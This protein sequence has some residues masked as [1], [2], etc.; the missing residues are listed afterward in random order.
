MRG[1]QVISRVGWNDQIIIVQIGVLFR[2]KELLLHGTIGINQNGPG[3]TGSMFIQVVGGNNF[4]DYVPLPW[5]EMP[6]STPR[7]SFGCWHIVKAQQ[8]V[9][10]SLHS[11]YICS[12]GPSDLATNF[13]P[14]HFIF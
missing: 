12:F 7:V 2:V 9:L 8:F 10:I 11:I 13:S 14:F 1:G 3:K 4:I 6:F 5:N